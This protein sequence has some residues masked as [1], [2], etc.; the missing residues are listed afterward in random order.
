M[1]E[2]WI[3]SDEADV[4]S[5]PSGNEAAW[6]I[7]G[8]GG[9][10]FLEAYLYN[11]SVS[12]GV[13]HDSL[14]GGEGN[15]YL[16][17][18]GGND[19]VCGG[20]GF[21]LIQGGYGADELYGGSDAHTETGND[22]IWG[23]MGDDFI[24][25]AA[26]RDVI[27][28][29]GGADQLRGWDGNDTL[30]GSGDS[31][32]DGAS[33]TLRG[34]DGDDV[35]IGGSGDDFLFGDIGADTL[36]G[37]GGSDF[38]RGGDANADVLAGGAGADMFFMGL[39]YGADRIV[40]EGNDMKEDCVSITNVRYENIN[41]W[42]EGNNLI[43]EMSDGSSLQIDDWFAAAPAERITSFL[44]TI[45]DNIVYAW[46]AGQGASVDL[47]SSIYASLDVS[48]AVSLDTG[49]VAML[50]GSLNDSLAAGVGADT[51]WGKTG[52]DT[53]NGAGGNDTFYYS[54]GDGHD[55]ILAS[56]ND[57][58]CWLNFGTVFCAKEVGCHVDFIWNCCCG[59]AER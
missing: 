46:N 18:D 3:G 56:S 48:R 26:G 35:L 49:A 32:P 2:I 50:G 8:M 4:F 41:T 59:C 17:G 36:H 47:G 22:S 44:F 7:Q 13:G 33:D 58:G 39:V 40:A 29:G 11:D 43:L 45:P 27:Y 34:G 51:L 6:N 54:R 23:G 25:G 21:D 31:I 52:N 20:N 30:Y 55:L 12:G 42:F 53:L 19:W 10:D 37:G 28:G 5:V 9:D 57:S 1:S 16:S 14:L 38:L 15:D 24:Y